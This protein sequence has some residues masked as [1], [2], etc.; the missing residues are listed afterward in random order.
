[1]RLVR[2]RAPGLLY[3]LHKQ[4]TPDITDTRLVS[5]V[6]LA[7]VA[8]E[9]EAANHLT[10]GEEAEALGR[11]D[12]AS[13]EGSLVQVAEALEDGGGLLGGRG[14]GGR[15][16]LGG[17]VEEGAGVLEGLSGVA[18]VALEGGQGTGRWMIREGN[19]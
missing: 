16:S 5:G 19:G 4:E 9:L 7:V 11:D 13:D 18:E 6:G 12:A 17:G 8:D 3:P 10:D 1:M 2:F 14:G 15:G